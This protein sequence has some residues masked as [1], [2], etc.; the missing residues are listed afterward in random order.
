MVLVQLDDYTPIAKQP[1]VIVASELF[2]LFL[3][4]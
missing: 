2:N 4:F 3:V 1:E